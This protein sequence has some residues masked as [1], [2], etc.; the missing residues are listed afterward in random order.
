[1]SFGS[2]SVAHPAFSSAKANVWLPSSVG[3]A[4]GPF[5][6]ACSPL[7][8]LQENPSWP[9]APKSTM[10]Y[11]GISSSYLPTNTVTL[12]AVEVPGAARTTVSAQHT[13]QTSWPAMRRRWWATER[14]LDFH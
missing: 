2:Y 12:N 5:R 8:T 10:G 13:V 14:T 6:A 11:K 9:A 1:M 4:L 3:N 7:L